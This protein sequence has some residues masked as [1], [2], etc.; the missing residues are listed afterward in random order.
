VR[1]E[2]GTHATAACGGGALARLLC[3]VG[4]SLSRDEATTAWVGERVRGDAFHPWHR[5]QP[6]ELHC[7]MVRDQLWRTAPS[8]RAPSPSL[9]RRTPIAYALL[10]ETGGHHGDAADEDVDAYGA[11]GPPVWPVTKAVSV[12]NASSSCACIARSSSSLMA[13]FRR[14]TWAAMPSLLHSKHFQSAIGPGE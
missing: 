13:A 1:T 12:C 2:A 14:W 9:G 7:N 8:Y 10:Q 6:Y 5:L 4:A 11:G 3:L